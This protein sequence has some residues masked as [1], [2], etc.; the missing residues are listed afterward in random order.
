MPVHSVGVTQIHP[1][2]RVGRAK[3]IPVWRRVGIVIGW[4]KKTTDDVEDEFSDVRWIDPSWLDTV[5]VDEISTWGDGHG[6]EEVEAE[7]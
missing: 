6:L 7:A 4:W 5:P 2:W 3:V 1:P